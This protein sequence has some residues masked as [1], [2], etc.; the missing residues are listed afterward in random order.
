MAKTA[1]HPRAPRF[2]EPAVDNSTVMSNSAFSQNCDVYNQ[3]CDTEK[4]WAFLKEY[5]V[6]CA[7]AY[8]DFFAPDTVDVLNFNLIKSLEYSPVFGWAGRLL[9][10]G[11]VL[12]EATV[13]S[14][15]NKI[16]YL[17]G[18]LKPRVTE[19]KQKA[20]K[21]V[22]VQANIRAAIPKQ[23]S[24][25]IGRLEELR[26]K[27]TDS[28]E[29]PDIK[30]EFSGFEKARAPHFAI[31]R[32]WAKPYL[33]EIVEIPR[34]EQLIEAYS[35]YTKKQLK[36]LKN[37]FAEIVELCGS[38]N[39]SK[40]VAKKNTR[41][42]RTKK[43][44]PAAEQVKAV[45][46]CAKYKTFTGVSATKV[47]GKSSIWV[48]NT[49]RRTLCNL[50]SELEGGF[51]VKGTTVIGI[52]E[53]SS[54]CKTIRE[55]KEGEILKLLSSGS[56]SAVRSILNTIKAKEKTLITRLGKDVIILRAE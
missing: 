55:N 22:D 29:I 23:S 50:R 28:W 12:E 48:Y 17:Y 39:V 56:K 2:V 45:T 44:K 14:L 42:P 16:K 11:A 27:M 32:G 51:S 31:I 38:E 26:D 43:V 24:E 20:P 30:K 9:V 41:K 18:I 35:C 46:V 21:K 5:V 54:H 19:I 3:N 36:M 52:N 1:D 15:D 8:P 47:P 6:W 10:R 4:S 33:E 7:D 53:N 37:F 25:Y 40:L 49:K 34:D 13:T